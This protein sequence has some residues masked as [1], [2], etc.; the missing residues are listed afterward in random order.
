MSAT[1]R[2]DRLLPNC[3]ELDVV[4]EF[5]QIAYSGDTWYVAGGYLRDKFLKKDF[6]DIDVFVT[7]EIDDWLPSGDGPNNRVKKVQTHH[8]KGVEINI[9]FMRG[10]FDFYSVVERCDLG[11]CQI[12]WNPI[13]DEVFNTDDFL[14]DVMGDTLTVCRDTRVDHIDRMKEKFPEK[15]LHN[16]SGFLLSPKSEGWWTYS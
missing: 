11:I 8:Y 7:G 6:K 5:M 16:P 4:K 14:C 10:V 9:I 3:P 2:A 13:T 1:V 15:R 12:G